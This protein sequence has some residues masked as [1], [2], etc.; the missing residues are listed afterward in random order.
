MASS[1]ITGNTLL[2]PGEEKLWAYEL[3]A[4]APPKLLWEQARLDPTTA[5]PVV[6][7]GRIYVLRGSILTVGELKTGEVLSQLRLKGNFSSSIVAAGGLIF[8]VNEDGVVQVVRPSE[9]DPA[10]INS[11]KF[12][13]TILCTPAATDGAFYLRSDKHFWKIGKT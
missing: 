13:E 3:Q 10:L 8:C 6:L 11:C 12:E 2:V 7:D 4:D 1:V 5:S 9:S